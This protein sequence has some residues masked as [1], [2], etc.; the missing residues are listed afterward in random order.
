MITLTKTRTQVLKEC[1]EYVIAK[2]NQD[3]F[4]LEDQDWFDDLARSAYRVDWQ[5][6]RDLLPKLAK[7]DHCL[8]HLKNSDAYIHYL[9]TQDPHDGRSM[10]DANDWRSAEHLWRYYCWTG[11]TRQGNKQD[12]INRRIW[13]ELFPDY[14]DNME[15]IRW[16]EGLIV[17]MQATKQQVWEEMATQA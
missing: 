4:Y 11:S 16:M 1:S 8:D 13:R 10:H 9:S 17:Q 12:K 14:H 2:H 15:T 7:S 3:K 5:Q 6:A